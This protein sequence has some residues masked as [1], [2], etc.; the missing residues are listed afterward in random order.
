M[1]V[2][3]GE[4]FWVPCLQLFHVISQAGY[5]GFEKV[6]DIVVGNSLNWPQDW[7]SRFP[8]LATV[9]TP[10]LSDPMDQIMWKGNNGENMEYSVKVVWETIRPCAATVNWFSVVWFS[11]CIP[12]HAFVLW[13]LMGEKLKTQDKLRQWELCPGSSLVWNLVTKHMDFSIVCDGWRD[14]RAI[15]SPF[16]NRNIA[17]IIVVKLLFAA[18]VYSIWQE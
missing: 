10:I 14:F 9:N 17:R 4:I 5:T 6:C 7:Y 15:L 3:V 8:I 16:A 18:S 1:Q 13:L 11:N 2:G 12:K